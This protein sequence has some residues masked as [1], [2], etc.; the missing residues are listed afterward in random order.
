MLED[1]DMKTVR[2]KLR[3]CEN[4]VGREWRRLSYF[5]LHSQI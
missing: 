2:N 3:K 4:D 1:N 5:E